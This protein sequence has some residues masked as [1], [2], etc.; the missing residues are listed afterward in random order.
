MTYRL[1]YVKMVSKSCQKQ[2]IHIFLLQNVRNFEDCFNILDVLIFALP[3][4][5]PYPGILVSTLS[6]ECTI[7]ENT[8]CN[9]CQFN[10]LSYKLCLTKISLVVRFARNFLSTYT[11]NTES[12]SAGAGW[13]PRSRSAHA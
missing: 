1:L 13:G 2:V 8:I 4:S 11:Q 3:V 5:V 9:E 10:I 6:C 7:T 12:I